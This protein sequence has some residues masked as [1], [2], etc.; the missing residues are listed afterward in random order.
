L[1]VYAGRSI[2]EKRATLYRVRGATTNS[3]ALTTSGSGIS[4][5]NYN[6]RNILTFTNLVPDSTGALYL[7]YQT[8]VGSYAHLNAISIEEVAPGGSAGPRMDSVLVDFGGVTTPNPTSGRHWNNASAA[9]PL[10][11]NLI[12]SGG[13][14]SGVRLE[15]TGGTVTNNDSLAVTPNATLG[16][17]NVSNAVVDGMYTTDANTGTTLKLSG[18]NR[19]NTYQLKLFGSRGD[20]ERRLTLYTVTGQGTNQAT[21]VTSGTNMSS[22]STNF[23]HT[24]VAVLT[25]LVPDTNGA[26]SVN[27]RVLGGQFAYLNALELSYPA[28][29]NALETWQTTYFPGD[30]TG[31]LAQPLSDPD[32]DGW[33][34][35][36]EFAQ[37]FS[38]TSP[39]GSQTEMGIRAVTNAVS[40]N[41][42]SFS[43]R[44]R[45]GSGTGTTESGYTVDGITYTLKAS[46]TLTTPS[47]QT[48]SSVLQQVGTPV[49][50]G[51]GTET[52]TVRILGTNPASFLKM[53]VSTP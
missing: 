20:P 40:T 30:P 32:G 51:D 14:N 22:G 34:N 52:V 13:T 44:R 50:N 18:L 4:S 6:N 35:L 49:N 46:P 31:T 11:T 17:F 41:A 9:A 24:V 3:G 16:V 29:L 43:F 12:N 37:G 8:M 33:V 39:S 38:P 23:N 45:I 28:A 7:D 27:Y 21:L 2:N 15:F 10:L 42:P 36:M 25:N 53:E 48:G 47:W 19:S 26:L 5:V 1:G